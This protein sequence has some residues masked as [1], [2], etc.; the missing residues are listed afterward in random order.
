[1]TKPLARVP[2]GRRSGLTVSRVGFG[3]APLGDFFEHLDETTAIATVET[4]FASGITLVDTSPHYGNGLAEHRI[5]TALRSV[6][7]D[8]VVISTKIGRVMSPASPGGAAPPPPAR[9]FVGSLPHRPRFDYSYDGVMRS[10]EQS[11][12]RLGTDRI[13]ILLIHDI[14]AWTH[15][16]DQVEA[17]Y[18]EALGSGYR[19]LDQLRA[20]GTV[21]AIGLGLDDHDWCERFLREAD[22]DAVLLAGR[23]SLLEQPALATLLP[24]A[25]AKGVGI[26]LGGI[27]NSGILATGAMAGARYNYEAAPPEIL[28][29][30]ARIEAVCRAHAVPLPRAAVQFVLG[31]P[32]VSTLVLGAVHPAEIARN[33]AALDEPVSAS[34]WSDLKAEGLLDPAAPAPEQEPPAL[35]IG[36]NA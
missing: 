10:F 27:F 12:L 25:L 34:L 8:S 28:D 18:R 36:E 4:A 16:E 11:L 14:D 35:R 22:F 7:R 1:M 3:S 31:H 21:K 15:G 20:E 6:P 32:A 19:A 9:G 13:D 5:G 2:L 26:M 29:R 33:L 23:Y 30:V 17:R 24:L